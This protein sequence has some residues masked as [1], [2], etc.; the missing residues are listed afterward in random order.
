MI[1]TKHWHDL[2]SKLVRDAL[3]RF[4][5]VATEQGSPGVATAA[6]ML[7]V[8]LRFMADD[9]SD[10]EGG[11]AWATRATYDELGN[12][13]GLSRT[14]VHAALRRLEA[15]KLITSEG[16]HQKR[17]YRFAWYEKDEK[18]GW[19]KLPCL[20]ITSANRVQ[21]FLNFKLRSK[22]ELHAMKLYLYIAAVRRNNA[23]HT[24]V[25]YEKI[26]E[27]LQ[28]PE[29]DVRRAISLLLTS[30]LL[31]SANR[32]NSGNPFEPVYG[33][34]KYYLTG[35]SN[36][37]RDLEAR[38]VVDEATKARWPADALDGFDRVQ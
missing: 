30:G 23:L 24:E 38:A 32:E 13:A 35:Y 3:P 5:W 1:R 26:N 10:E 29:R 18:G 33:P 21:P 34:N 16:S 19:F 6:L 7:Y 31:A 9:V 25:T 37:L 20:A 17:S 36:L 11:K 4:T 12:A 15:E 8:V 2:P 14:M 22:H 28:I 27:R